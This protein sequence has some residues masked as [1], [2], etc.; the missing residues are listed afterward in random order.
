[1]HERGCI[2]A[3]ASDEPNRF[4]TTQPRIL[5]YPR[6]MRAAS[7]WLLPLLTAAAL[8]V[9][10]PLQGQQA[11]DNFRWVDFHSASDQDVVAWVTRSLEPEKWTAIREI[12]VEYDAA[13]V[14]TTVRPD[15]QSQPG[16]DSFTVWSLS[17]T[18]HT[19]APLLKGVNLRLLDWLL[20]A[21]GEPR[22]LGA[23]YDDCNEC[24]ATTFFTAFHYDLSQH[25]WA[26]RWMRGTQA[27]PIWSASPSAGVA[28]TQVYALLAEP[29]GR[30]LMGTWSH[31]DDGKQKS[32]ENVVFRYDL[33]TFNGL[34][35]TQ[36]LSGKEADAM[37]Q[38]LC[39]A[40]PIAPELA[41]GQDSPLCQQTLKPLPVR[42]PVT[43]PPANNHGQSV[44]PKTRR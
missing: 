31:F 13:I 9:A 37:K 24:A 8:T 41:R 6:L 25:M 14:I 33:D 20:L 11:P 27:A 15:P 29:N 32:P 44:P 22:E 38:R 12:G 40:Q 17:L 43:T 21:D 39:A 4:R 19:L 42:R 1:M 26:A 2:C 36:L 7:S 3:A 34:E 5:L 16:A 35:R 23:L 18:S 28:L 10:A 30:E